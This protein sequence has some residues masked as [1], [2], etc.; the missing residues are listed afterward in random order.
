MPAKVRGARRA[1]SCKGAGRS[2][3]HKNQKGNT[4]AKIDFDH[5]VDGRHPQAALVSNLGA[6]PFSAVRTFSHLAAVKTPPTGHEIWAPYAQALDQPTNA[7]TRATKICG[8]RQGGQRSIGVW[9]LSPTLRATFFGNPG[10]RSG[11]AAAQ[12]P[13]FRIFLGR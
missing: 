2:E 9:G 3:R 11:G 4:V 7:A 12:L 1:M 6:A 13:I 8:S 10:H 5:L